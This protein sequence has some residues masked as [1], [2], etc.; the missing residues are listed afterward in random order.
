MQFINR[1]SRSRR[2][3]FVTIVR[4][5]VT[6]RDAFVV[7]VDGIGVPRLA[8]RNDLVRDRWW[9]VRVGHP[10]QFSQQFLQFAYERR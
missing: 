6:R 8:P 5:L 3:C 10:V 1:R 2:P 9:S 7:L 4:P